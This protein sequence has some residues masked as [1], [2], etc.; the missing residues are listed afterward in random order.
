M[1]EVYA[2]NIKY[3]NKNLNYNMDMI[4]SERKERIKRLKFVDDKKACFFAEYILYI[5]MKYI[6]NKEYTI[7]KDEN[8]KPKFQ[9]V[10]GFHFNISHSGDWVIC[11][12]SNYEIGIDIEKIDEVNLSIAKKY[13]NI[14]EYNVLLNINNSADKKS[15]FYTLWTLKESYLKNLGIGIM[16]ISP[17]LKF[18]M[19]NS[20]EG[21]VDENKID[22][23]FFSQRF[24]KDYI[25]SICYDEKEELN[26]SK[27]IN[28]L[29]VM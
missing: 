10:E 5:C 18:I 11:A 27:F 24:Q 14:D 19:E 3:I 6:Y 23:S 17:K 26:E 9:D 12:F 29:N 15:F 25:I 21:Y 20:I 7:K 13:F 28:I 22:K 2:I 1:I 16:G 4:S 8:G